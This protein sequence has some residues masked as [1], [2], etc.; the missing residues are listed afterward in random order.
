ME[1]G[2]ACLGK[3]ASDK[4]S[5]AQLE[6]EGVVGTRIPLAAPTG[7]CPVSIEA[8]HAH[9]PG[10]SGKPRPARSFFL[11]LV[12]GDHGELDSKQSSHPSPQPR[13]CR[14]THAVGQGRMALATRQPCPA[15]PGLF[16]HQP[17][18]GAGSIGH[19]ATRQ[20]ADCMLRRLRGPA[21]PPLAPAGT[22]GQEGGGGARRRQEGG[23]PRQ[24]CQPAL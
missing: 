18:P 16:K 12:A 6:R 2:E 9:H 5:E 8:Q 23:G 21:R 24:A 3:G 15:Q 14:R 4:A 10:G 19:P 7:A 11:T 20:A 22:Q 1:D 13:C 17:G